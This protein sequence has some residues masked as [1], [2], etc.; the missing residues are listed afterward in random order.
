MILLIHCKNL[1][2]VSA[3]LEKSD[4]FKDE[5]TLT[6]LNAENVNKLYA[7]LTPL[8]IYKSCDSGTFV[9]LN[10]NCFIKLF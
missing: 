7:E 2:L 10:T 3:V 8:L 6:K 4:K 1:I 5:V 9:I